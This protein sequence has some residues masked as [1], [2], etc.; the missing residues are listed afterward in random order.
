MATQVHRDEPEPLGQRG[1]GQLR[2]PGPG[3]LRPA[4]HKNDRPAVFG[5]LD[6]QAEPRPAVPDDFGAHGYFAPIPCQADQ[7]KF[8][9]LTSEFIGAP[10]CEP[11]IST[12]SPTSAESK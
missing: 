12:G 7:E 1:V 9:S 8:Q 5:A 3:R 6:P 4:V 11:V 10:S 2:R